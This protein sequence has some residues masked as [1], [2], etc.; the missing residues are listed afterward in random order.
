MGI[1]E[2]R[3]AGLLR[4]KDI[5]EAALVAEGR[6][7]AVDPAGGTRAFGTFQDWSVLIWR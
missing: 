3:L 1:D 7:A 2:R 4:A 5:A 6:T